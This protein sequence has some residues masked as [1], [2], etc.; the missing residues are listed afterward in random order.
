VRLCRILFAALLTLV[1]CSSA[2][3]GHGALSSPGSP[4]APS[5]TSSATT[6]DCPATAIT[7]TGAPFCYER[8]PG[9]TDNSSLNSYGGKWAYKTLVSTARYDL[10]EV[11][12]SRL[13]F[14]S[15]AYSDAKLAA[16]ADRLRFHPGDSGLLNVRS[17]T[18][19]RVADTRAYQQSATTPLGAHVRAIYAFRGTSVVYIQC[20]R[21]D[22]P[23]KADAGCDAV[24]ASIQIISLG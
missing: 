21:R 20:E 18:P 24:L 2:T 16:Y 10:V 17:L 6:L 3:S 12:A 1:A 5:A 4:P 13:S 14:D 15:D 22:Q 23:S 8:P 9:F 19:T 7:K 11:L